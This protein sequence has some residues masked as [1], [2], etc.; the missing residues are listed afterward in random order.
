MSSTNKYNKSKD[1]NTQHNTTDVAGSPVNQPS[2]SHQHPTPKP[3][4]P[5]PT[6]PSPTPKPQNPPQPRGKKRQRALSD[7]Q[8]ATV[9]AVLQRGGDMVGRSHIAYAAQ[10]LELQLT[11][12][13]LDVMIDR[14]Q[15][16]TGGERMLTYE[17]FCT[18][19]QQLF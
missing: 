8:V 15:E 3:P 17:A 9:F 14:V 16:H 19:A 2:P 7:D 1:H 4:A 12:D 10:Q 5:T 11:E 6:N 18:L 13:E